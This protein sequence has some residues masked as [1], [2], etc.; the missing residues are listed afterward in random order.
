ME[1]VEKKGG[2][3]VFPLLLMDQDNV[4]REVTSGWESG[5]LTTQIMRHPTVHEVQPCWYM[6]NPE[7]SRPWALVRS[8]G[9]PKSLF[10]TRAKREREFRLDRF[11]LL[12]IIATNEKRS[13]YNSL[14]NNFF[15]NC[16]YFAP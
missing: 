9:K 6:I 2:E 15:I 4:L 5:Y 3:E 16:Y 12:M 11:Q 7:L 13:L 14:N 1:E 10:S 8:E